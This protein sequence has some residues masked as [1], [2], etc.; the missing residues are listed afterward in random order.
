MNSIVGRKFNLFTEV[1]RSKITAADASTGLV[2]D[3]ECFDATRLILVAEVRDKELTMDQIIYKLHKSRSRGVSELLFLAQKGILKTDESE[4]LKFIEREFSSGQNIYI[5]PLSAF[6]SS[7]L[8]LL[9][10]AGRKEFLVNVSNMLDKYG[11]AIQHRRA[12][13]KLLSEI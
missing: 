4:V 8:V 2:D 12:W 5:L 7:L 11:S 6:A 9:G 3:I 1:R 10:E 13:A